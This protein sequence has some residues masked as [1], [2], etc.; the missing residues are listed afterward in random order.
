MGGFVGTANI[1]LLHEMAEEMK[2]RRLDAVGF[3]EDGN[4][5][6]NLCHARLSVLDLD[7]GYQPI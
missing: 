2:F 1:N 3:Y 6:V 7:S 4:D 5:G